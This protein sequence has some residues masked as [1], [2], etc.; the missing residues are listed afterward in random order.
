MGDESR[1]IQREA[2]EHELEGADREARGKV[3]KNVGKLTDDK[4]REAKGTVK[5]AAGKVQKE[6]GRQTRK[7]SE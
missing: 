6:A 2:T 4:S 1:K 5:E 3:E 7:A